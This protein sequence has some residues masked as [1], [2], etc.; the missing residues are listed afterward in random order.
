MYLNQTVLEQYR[1]SDVLTCDP[2]KLVD[3]RNVR[4]DTSRPVQERL[5]GFVQQI[6][7]PYLFKVDGLIVKTTYL[8]QANRRLCDAIPGLL[9]P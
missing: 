3:L 6:E 7:N 5:E 1:N 8:P 4:I 2:R 9:V